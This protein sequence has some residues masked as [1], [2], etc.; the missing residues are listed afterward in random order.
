MDFPAPVFQT[1]DRLTL[2]SVPKLDFRTPVSATF[3]G[4]EIHPLI[5][6]KEIKYKSI[7]HQSNQYAEG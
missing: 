5:N 1:V 3:I 4:A 2:R 6:Q 7:I